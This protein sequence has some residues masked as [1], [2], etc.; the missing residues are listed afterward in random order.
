M[1]D[2][3]QQ[4]SG[5]SSNIERLANELADTNRYLRYTF[6]FKMIVVRGLITGF[7]IV[8]GS[9]VLASILFS[10]VQ[11]LFGDVPFVPDVY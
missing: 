8:I 6:S 2:N 4:N 7:A 3:N 9:T 5:P 1:E 11:V 10:I